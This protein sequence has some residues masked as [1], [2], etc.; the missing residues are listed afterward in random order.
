MTQDFFDPLIGP[1]WKGFPQ[2]SGALRRSAIAAM[3]WNLLRG[4]L[5][6][7]LAVIRADALAGNLRWMQRFAGEHG[8]DLAPHGKTSMSPQLF[9]RQLQAGAW[10]MTF[11]N[12]TQAWIGAHAG[13]RKLLIAN[14]VFA[15]ADLDALRTL[16]GDFPDARLQFLVDS[17]AQLELIEAWFSARAGVPP[18]E[19]LL[20]LGLAG[21]RTGCRE[22]AQAMALARRLHASAAVRLVGVECYEGLWASGDEARDR[23]LVDGLLGSAVRLASQC[24]AEGL[25]ECD[26][27]LVSAGGSSVFDLVAPWLTPR[28][29]KPVRGLLRSGCYVTHDHGGYK[30]LMNAMNARLP[31]AHGL[32]G[33]LEVW[34]QVQSCPE[35]GLA[36][37]NA[38]KR[39]L[40][41]DQE[42]PHPLRWQ[43][44][45]EDGAGAAPADWTIAALNDQHA[46][47]RWPIGAAAGPRVGDRVGLG[48]SHP[49]TTFDK[50]RWMALVDARYEV[51]DAIVTYF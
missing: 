31:C 29:S 49:C 37:L 7:P 38:G 47:L 35:P 2:H 1:G 25:F 21:G 17:P 19:V 16:R 24:D 41:Y 26:E 10:G 3:G 44:H 39:D 50:W 28:L 8:V 20:E 48:I 23:A 22:P 33:A 30:R 4:E 42:M 36:I 18:F 34:T 51:V 15:A 6:L 45:G 43:R 46:Y 14:Q 9:A 13:V 5:P 40:S 11:A 27:V 12:V 32:Q